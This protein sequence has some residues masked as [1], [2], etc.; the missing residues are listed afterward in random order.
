M[1]QRGLTLIELIVVIAVIAILAGTMIPTTAAILDLE[2]QNATQ[3][4]MDA[5]STAIRYLYDDNDRFPAQLS[6]LSSAANPGGYPNWRGPYISA[7]FLSTEITDNSV[8]YDK[9]RQLYRFQDLGG[10]QFL[11]WSPGADRAF[12]ANY[13]NPGDDIVK[14]VVATDIIAKKTANRI[15]R[16]LEEMSLI[17]VAIVNYNKTV[18][19]NPNLVPYRGNWVA[20]LNIL[21]ARSFVAPGAEYLTDAWGR[22]YTFD[23]SRVSAPPECP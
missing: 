11:I 19:P 15:T 16:T 2:R 23:G 22:Q 18:P 17:N 7:K 13:T 6:H 1:Q 5:L 12:S 4:N 8:L 9:W 10:G 3:A 20:A 21:Q 14:I